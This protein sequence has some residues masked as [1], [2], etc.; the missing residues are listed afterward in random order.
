MLKNGMGHRQTRVTVLNT[1]E[2]IAG[3]ELPGAN[4]EPKEQKV[5]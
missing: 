5:S 2:L 1:I 3:E 4:L